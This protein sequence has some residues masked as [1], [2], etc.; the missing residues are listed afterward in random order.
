LNN[1]A[2]VVSYVVTDSAAN[3]TTNI[4]ALQGLLTAGKLSSVSLTDSGTTVLNL[5]QAQYGADVGVLALI[6]GNYT[7]DINGVAVQQKSVMPSGSFEVAY[8]NLQG[9]AYASYEDIYSPSGIKVAESLNNNNGT[10]SIALYSDG[11]TISSSTTQDNIQVGLDNFS[12]INHSSETIDATGYSN[13]TFVFTQTFGQDAISGFV[14]TGGMH[15]ILQFDAAAFGM[16]SSDSQAADLAAL[17]THTQN[18]GGNAVIT[19]IHGNSVTLTGV[20]TG[21]LADPANAA[22]FKFV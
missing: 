21:T 22:N 14:A 6:S 10:G 18:I 20:S 16:T 12:L 9:Q 5:T 11:L 2:H 13:E 4:D 15:D 1:D 7:V 17:L 19:D 3:V 8:T